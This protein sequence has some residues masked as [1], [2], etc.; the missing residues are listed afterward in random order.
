M[1]SFSV[2]ALRQFMG[3][4]PEQLFWVGLD[5][6][7][8]SYSVALRRDD[9]EVFTWTCPADPDGLLRAL[10]R[11]GIGVYGIC[12]E[13]GPTGFTLARTFREAGIPVVVAAPSKIPRSV[14]PG[15]K[16]DRLDCIKLARYAARGMIRGITV[17]SREE[18]W[19]RSLIRRRH[20]LVDNLRRCKQRVRAL[21]L[22]HG[23]EEPTSV[24][25]WRKDWF[26][27][28][29]DL[30]IEGAARLTIESH[31]REYVHLR[32]EL[33]VIE[34]QLM[35]IVQSP[36]HIAVYR[37]LTSVPGVGPITATTF[38]LEVFDPQ[39]FNRAEEIASYL[40]LA[41]TVRHSGGSAP[42]GHLVSVGQ[43]RLRSLL[44]EASWAWKSKDPYAQQQYGKLLSRS[45]VPQKAISAVARK[46]AIILWRLS[47]EQRA[48]RSAAH[49]A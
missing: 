34:Q 26:S 4:D 21:L 17:P 10:E 36:E 9:D 1:A 44:V 7:K 3:I 25:T 45:G 41:P 48:Y 13:A 30:P 40:G 6:H 19:E 31:A 47:I 39:R 35:T 38:I 29:R 15:S 24:C 11:Y 32:D 14:S 28:I 42:R 43:K 22:F 37:A 46:L 8:R 5:V 27:T 18:E 2:N 16:T 12:H 23:I 33:K 49:A 20:Q